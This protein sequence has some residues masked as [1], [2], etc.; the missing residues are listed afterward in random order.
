MRTKY[1]M[2][3]GTY[4]KSSL[5]EGVAMMVKSNTMLMVYPQGTGATVVTTAT[6]THTER[7]DTTPLN[8]MDV[9]KD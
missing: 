2:K 5:A 9:A 1:S 8:T 6:N 3:I 4:Q 7:I